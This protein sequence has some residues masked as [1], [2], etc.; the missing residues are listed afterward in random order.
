[1]RCSKAL[2]PEHKGIANAIGNVLVSKHWHLTCLHCSNFPSIG[3][4]S[5]SSFAFAMHHAGMMMIIAIAVRA[6][7]AVLEGK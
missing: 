4:K 3:K 5:P 1:M 6:Q 7:N 2:P